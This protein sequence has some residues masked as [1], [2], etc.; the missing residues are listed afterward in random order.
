MSPSTDQF[1]PA[2]LE[3]DTLD[4]LIAFAGTLADAAAAETLPLF[5]TINSIDNKAVGHDFDP[6][7]AADRNAEKVLRTLIEDRYPDH[8]IVGEE[9]GRKD[10]SSPFS[11]VLD[12]IDG[13]AGYI[14]GSP[15][16]TTL[17]G[18]AHEGVPILGI[19]DQPFIGERF[20]G[21]E[22]QARLSA[23]YERNN[24]HQVIRTSTCQAVSEAILTT[25]SPYL[26]S[27]QE[28]PQYKTVESA[29]RLTRYGLDGY[30]Y[31]LLSLGA[32]DLVVEAG[33]AAYDIQPLI[34]VIRGAGGVVTN[35]DGALPLDGGQIVAAATA[36]LHAEALKLLNA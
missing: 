23:W 27:A 22:T 12:P 21:V 35:W 32:M 26:F 7:T 16:W 30:G 25:T 9:W 33:L 5:R 6:V 28:R 34:P 29:A 18:L 36:D 15:A 14:A 4:E 8:A 10:G 3:S 1:T 24:T 20:T 17:I 13:T 19:I 31:G 11:W 2:S